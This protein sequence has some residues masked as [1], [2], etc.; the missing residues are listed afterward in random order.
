MSQKSLTN[1]CRLIN[2]FAFKQNNHSIV[3][4]TRHG[5]NVLKKIYYSI[6][7]VNYLC[8]YQFLSIFESIGIKRKNKIG[9]FC[10]KLFVINYFKGVEVLFLG[11]LKFLLLFLF[12]ELSITMTESEFYIII[13]IGNLFYSR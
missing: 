4:M 8:F 6:Q 9:F 11:Q 2:W 13:V 10:G 12:S 5:F 7:F 3:S 1:C